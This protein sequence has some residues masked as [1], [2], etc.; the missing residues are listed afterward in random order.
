M[1][2]T[3]VSSEA[4]V[5]TTTPTAAD[6][7]FFRCGCEH[8][9]SAGAFP[10]GRRSPR[11]SPGGLAPA[12]PQLTSAIQHFAAGVVFAALAGE[13]LPELRREGQ[14]GWVLLGFTGGV[15]L[16]L[17]LDAYAERQE[18]DTIDRRGALPLGLL[19]AVAIDLLIDGL[20]VGL[21]AT[22]GDKQGLIITIALT[23][24]ILF[25]AVSVS[26]GLLDQGVSRVRA[27]VISGGL[28][29][30]CAVGALVGA[31]VLGSAGTNV[32]A[33]VLAFGAAALLYLVVEELLV[34][35]HEAKETPLLAAMFFVGFIGLFALAG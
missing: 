28:G 13:V 15:V 33:A 17:G 11:G 23:I 16:L 35:A 9:R 12:R 26:I 21:G 8:R 5:I 7:A 29:L 32:L 1:R 6:G 27:G 10:G 2:A 31:A 22:L 3:P 20:L 24:E 25:L 14:L 4:P 30:F 18:T 34:E 19:S